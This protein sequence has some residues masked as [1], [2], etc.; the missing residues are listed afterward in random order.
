MLNLIVKITLLKFVLPNLQ[1]FLPN[2]HNFLPNLSIYTASMF[3]DKMQIANIIF[4]KNDLP[5][6]ITV[7]LILILCKHLNDFNIIFQLGC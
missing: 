5:F 1:N 7:K 6:H 4:K 3:F 2:L